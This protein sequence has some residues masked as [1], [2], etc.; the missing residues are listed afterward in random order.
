LLELIGRGSTILETRRASEIDA[1]AARRASLDRIVFWGPPAD[2]SVPEMAGEYAQS[3]GVEGQSSLM[4]VTPE[5]G[6]V[7]D[8]LP[9][10]SIFVWPRDLDRLR[11]A[12]LTG[13]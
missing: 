6:V 4:C 13:A 8:D 7:P 12:V 10:E 3:R 11:M 5:N 2:P 9:A 1:T